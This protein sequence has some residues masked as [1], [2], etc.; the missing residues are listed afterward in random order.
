MTTILVIDD[1]SD[2]REMLRE[3]LES[4]G[5]KVLEAEDGVIGLR[6]YRENLPNL[7]ITDLVMPNKEG[8][9]LI[10]EMRSEFPKA[11][12]IAISG[13]GR[14]DPYTYL[15]AAKELGAMCTLRKPF[16]RKKLLAT[17]ENCLAG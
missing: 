13:G 8:I 4:A 9:G 6:H 2:Y 16:E 3:M 11:K 17:V 1:D 15:Q 12:I 5:Y 14:A 10:M 7:I